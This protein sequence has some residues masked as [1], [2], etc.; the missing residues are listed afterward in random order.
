M[1][2]DHRLRS[3]EDQVAAPARAQP[4]SHDPQELVRD[5]ERRPRPAGAGEDRELVAQ[6]QVL[7]DQVGM[8][9]QHGREDPEKQGE[10]VEHA[11]R[12]HDPGPLGSFCPPTAGDLA[13]SSASCVRW[14]PNLPS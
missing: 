14:I 1:P 2:A 6:E 11:R 13:S 4:A 10:E 9:A 12:M 8:A 5:A 7:G 3:D